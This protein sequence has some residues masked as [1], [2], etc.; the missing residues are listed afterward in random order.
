MGYGHAWVWTH[1]LG[2]QELAARIRSDEIDILVDCIGHTR[3]TRLDALASKPAPVMVSWLGYLGTTGLPAMDFR[4]RACEF[5]N[6]ADGFDAAKLARVAQGHADSIREEGCL[7]ERACVD[8]DPDGSPR[9]VVLAY[10]QRLRP[11]TR[12]SR[13]SSA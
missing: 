12:S 4:L 11:Q 8:A 3:G 2:D 1:T 10:F 13:P 6:F 5:F 7:V 9:R